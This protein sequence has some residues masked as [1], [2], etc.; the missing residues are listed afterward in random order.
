MLPISRTKLAIRCVGVAMMPNAYKPLSILRAARARS[1]WQRPLNIQITNYHKRPDT[2]HRGRVGRYPD[3][4]R[5]AD[6]RPHTP[7]RLVAEKFQL[8]WY[9]RRGDFAVIHA[10]GRRT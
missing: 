6:L 5:C 8:G 9:V 2:H 4:C 10:Y 7:I 1:P 3:R